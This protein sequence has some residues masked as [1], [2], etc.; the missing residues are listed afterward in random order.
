M[1]GREVSSLVRKT[2]ESKEMDLSVAKSGC[3]QVMVSLPLSFLLFHILILGLTCYSFTHS[4]SLLL[5][6]SV[7]LWLVQEKRGEEE[8]H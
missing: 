6:S 4:L 3:P 1:T 7:S 2:K 8:R 5:S